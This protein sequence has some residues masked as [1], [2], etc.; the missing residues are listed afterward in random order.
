M[1]VVRFLFQ[2]EEA[3]R[4][5]KKQKTK[6]NKI[7]IF[8]FKVE[9]LFDVF[10]SIQNWHA[11]YI[12]AESDSDLLFLDENTSLKEFLEIEKNCRKKVYIF[13]CLYYE[14]SCSNLGAQ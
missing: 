7:P 9:M 4:Q 10:S 14:K 2:I 5:T 3:I 12:V 6:T 8:H 1:F 11:K 13:F